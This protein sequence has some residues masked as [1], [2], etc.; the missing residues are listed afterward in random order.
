MVDVGPHPLPGEVG[1]LERVDVDLGG[2]VAHVAH[3]APVLHGGHVLAGDHV[4]VA[5]AGHHLG[6]QKGTMLQAFLKNTRWSEKKK[7]ACF[8]F[9]CTEVKKKKRPK[10]LVYGSWR[11]C[12][13]SFKKEKFFLLLSTTFGSLVPKK[14]EKSSFWDCFGSAK[15]KPPPLLQTFEGWDR[16]VVEKA[17]GE[18]GIGS[19][20]RS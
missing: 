11:H 4:L 14:K 20:N 16:A 3:D 15:K 5:R 18:E 2:G 9:S 8:P 10:N 19:L 17:K 12:Y 1:R 6:Q 7:T 13:S